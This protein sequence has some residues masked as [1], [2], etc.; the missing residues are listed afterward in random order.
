MREVV[1]CSNV[2][3]TGRGERKPK[4]RGYANCN[5]CEQYSRAAGVV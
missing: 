5:E 2:R 3:I 4:E 1:A